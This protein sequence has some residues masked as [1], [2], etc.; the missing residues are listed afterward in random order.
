M[1]RLIHTFTVPS[2]LAATTVGVQ[3]GHAGRLG[4]AACPT[5]AV[6]SAA[7]HAACHHRAAEGRFQARET[8]LPR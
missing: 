5:A 3:A 8:R 2:A 6:T 7:D 4:P 1:R